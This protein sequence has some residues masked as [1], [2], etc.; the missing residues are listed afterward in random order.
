MI[1]ISIRIDKLAGD[2]VQPVGPDKVHQLFRPQLDADPAAGPAYEF[3]AACPREWKEVVHD[4]DSQ[5]PA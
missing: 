3:V 5:L 1:Y 4:D 2:C